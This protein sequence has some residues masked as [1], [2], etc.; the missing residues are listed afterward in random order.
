MVTS[1]VR[2]GTPAATTRGFGVEEFRQV[3]QFIS[4][5]LDGLAENREDNSKAEAEVL[6]KV[7]KLCRAF[8]IY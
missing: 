6:D 4:E 5:V 2:L 3:G 1:G 7:H 8:P